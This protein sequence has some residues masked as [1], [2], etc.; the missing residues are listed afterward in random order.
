MSDQLE[1]IINT[2]GADN[3][4]CPRCGNY[5]AMLTNYSYRGDEATDGK[6]LSTCRDCGHQAYVVTEGANQ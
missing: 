1:T 2:N 4:S 6:G 3:A 5:N